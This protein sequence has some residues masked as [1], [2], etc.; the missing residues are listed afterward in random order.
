V[1]Q[2]RLYSQ[3]DTKTAVIQNGGSVSGSIDLAATALIGFIAPS[4][5]TAA[6]MQIEVS[7][8]NST[9]ATVVQDQ[10]GS[11]TGN[12][13][14]ITAAAAYA[15]DAVGLLPYRYVRLRSG[16][17]ASPVNQGA[18]RAFTLITRPLA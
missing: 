16:S 13:S 8:D 11:A 6:A 12:Y 1:E 3:R 14:A 2:V 10:Y 17:A 18:D 4:E 9:W 7:T 15:V 5:W